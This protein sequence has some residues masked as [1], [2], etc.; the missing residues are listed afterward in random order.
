MR[1]WPRRARAA[2]RLDDVITSVKQ[3]DQFFGEVAGQY[4]KAI[5]DN[6]LEISAMV[7]GFIAA[8]ALST[9]LAATPTGVGRVRGSA[10]PAGPG[11][12]REPMASSR[13]VERP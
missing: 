10:H 3:A 12:V 1:R 7:V 5:R 11:G 13:P 2:Q 6:W 4:G 8:E 9:F